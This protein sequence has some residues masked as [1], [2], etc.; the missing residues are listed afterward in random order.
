MSPIASL[1]STERDFSVDLPV[2]DLVVLLLIFSQAWEST[3][4]WQ[5][6]RR[7]RVSLARSTL[8]KRMDLLGFAEQGVAADFLANGGEWVYDLDRNDLGDSDDLDSDEGS[9]KSAAYLQK[10]IESGASFQWPAWSNESARLARELAIYWV[11]EHESYPRESTVIRTAL[12]AFRPD[13]KVYVRISQQALF[14]LTPGEVEWQEDEFPLP[15]SLERYRSSLAW[16]NTK[17]IVLVEGSFDCKVIRAAFEVRCPDYADCLSVADFS[18]G[19]EGGAG[20]LRRTLRTLAQ[21]EIPNTIV[22][23]FDNDAAGVEAMD[24]LDKDK[25]PRHIGYAVYPEMDFAR[26]YPTI[27]PTGHA[28]ADINGRA[29]SVEHF[30]GFDCLTCEGALAP[31][32]WTGYNRRVGVY[33]GSVIGKARI[34]SNFEKKLKR[35]RLHE[36]DANDDWGGLQV[37]A[38]FVIQ[39]ICQVAGRR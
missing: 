16:K 20:G 28:L 17:P 10:M 4:P 25:L 29:L 7:K 12:R 30:L 5:N 38:N 21:L 35:A 2:A 14:D 22:G 11:D 15:L 31:V 8:L 33:Q 27:G 24:L 23:L 39:Q 36:S 9:K 6:Q 26:S 13:E 1:H 32:E 34:Q 3:D 19:A 18:Q 37:L